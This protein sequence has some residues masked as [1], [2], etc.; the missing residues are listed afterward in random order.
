MPHSTHATHTPPPPKRNTQRQQQTTAAVAGFLQEA[1]G[2]PG[3]RLQTRLARDNAWQWLQLLGGAGLADLA[4]QCVAFLAASDDP[5]RS[6]KD[7]Q[8]LQPRDAEALVEA[9]TRRLADA[10]RDIADLRTDLMAS[11]REASLLRDK[12]E[13]RY[14]RKEVAVPSGGRC[15]GCQYSTFDKPNGK[16]A[17]FCLNCGE[18]LARCF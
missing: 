10:A 3:S 12:V 1:D 16:P 13:A 8:S 18:N 4:A 15:P 9:V 5:L 14:A 11:A 7:L 17:R 2:P 6:F